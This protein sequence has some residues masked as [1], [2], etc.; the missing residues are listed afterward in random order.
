MSL[1]GF[2]IFTDGKLSVYDNTKNKYV[3]DAY[4]PSAGSGYKNDT[5]LHCLWFK[6]IILTPIY[7]FRI[8][9]NISLIK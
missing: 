5:T 9:I 4:L 7:I 8:E 1:E 2:D 6:K 3:Y